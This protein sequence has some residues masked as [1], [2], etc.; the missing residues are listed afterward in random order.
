MATFLLL[1][2]H[3]WY[4]ASPP[5]ALDYVAGELERASITSKIVDVMFTEKEE[6]ESLVQ[7]NQYDG[8]CLTIRNLERTIF[9]E[10]LHFPLPAIRELVQFL[11]KYCDCPIIVGG[12]GF[13]ILPERILEYLKADYGIYGAGEEALPLL[14]RYLFENQGNLEEIPHLVYRQGTTIKRNKEFPYRRK[15]PPVKRGYINY[16]CYFRPGHEH[17]PGFGAVETKRGCPYQCVYCVEPVTKG[18]IV[19]VKSPKDTTKEVDWFLSRG[20][21][22]L[23]LTDSEFNT[24]SD[25]ACSLLTYWKERGY[26]RKMRWMAYATPSP[27]SEELAEL[28]PQS[29]NLRTVFDFGHVSNSMLSNLGKTFT[30]QHIEDTIS[31]CHKYN[32]AFRGSLMLGGPG[33]TRETIREAIE[34]FK[35]VNCKIF[36]VLGIRVF[37]HTVLGEEIQKS[38]PLVDNPNLCGKVI[39]NDDL[40]EPVYYISSELGEDVFDYLS[41]LIGPTEQFYTAAS[42]FTLTRQMHGPFRGVKPEYETTGELDAQYITNLPEREISTPIYGEEETL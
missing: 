35:E 40:L 18:R 3:K 37:P 5:V 11:R 25:A 6:L 36:F 2:A 33:E 7:R 30:L 12:N 9:S 15:L 24:D 10:K 14:I 27:F 34:F 26:H 13:S 1:N 19:R 20:I 21:T 4:P 41:E 16:R 23:F 29:G 38:G 17:F 28:L 32:V 31:Y 42:P 8:V 39:N 22:Y